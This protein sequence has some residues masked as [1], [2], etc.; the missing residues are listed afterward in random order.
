[1]FVSL[2]LIFASTSHAQIRSTLNPQS[3]A[4]REQA[5]SDLRT[6]ANRRASTVEREKKIA[7]VSLK[8]DFRQLQIVELDLMKRVFGPK[9][10]DAEAISR[11]EI[12]ASL[13]EIQNRAQRFK[14]NFQLPD[15][16]EVKADK[17]TKE[18]ASEFAT[19]SAGLLM[20][21][22]TVTKFVEN[23]IFQ[24]L[25]VLDAELSVQAAQDLNKILRLTDSLRR[26]AK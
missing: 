18:R 7:L 12:R 25:K 10:N 1:L 21:D 9:A 23:P 26:L 3:I 20:L 17:P 5:L 22:Q 19:L 8:E 16:K 4:S 2:S 11:K 14:L 6:N 13:G 15:V 24:Q